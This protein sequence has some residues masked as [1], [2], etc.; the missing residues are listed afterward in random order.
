MFLQWS[1]SYMIITLIALLLMLLSGYRYMDVLRSNLEHT[2]GIQLDMTRV[3]LDQKLELLRNIT[4]KE[5]FS[6]AIS[7]MRKTT[8][9]DETPRYNYYQLT[10]EVTSDVLDYG[11]GNVYFLYF[12]AI[13]AMVSNAYYGQSQWFYDITLKPY[14]ISYD[15]W[16]EILGQE[17]GSTQVFVPDIQGEGDKRY[18]ILVRPISRSARADN[19]VNAVLMIDMDDLMQASDWLSQDT[20]CIV[21]RNMD[22]FISTQPVEEDVAQQIM[23]RLDS[24]VTQKITRAEH[25]VEDGLYISMI[26]S[27]Y[28]NWDIAV[29]I[30]EERF[31]SKIMDV[32]KLIACMILVYLVLIALVVA[33]SA[34]NH[35][36]RLKNIV[37]ALSG[38]DPDAD[39]SMQD[40]Y[41]YIDTSVQRLVRANVENSDVI[42]RQRNA[43][44]RELFLTLVAS[45]NTPVEI[46]EES[47]R[48]SGFPAGENEAYY[49]MGYRLEKDNPEEENDPNQISEMEWFILQNVTEES[50]QARGLMELCFRKGDTQVY[51]IWSQR[52]DPQTLEYIQEACRF[53]REFLAQHFDFRYTAAISGSHT[54]AAGMYRAWRELRRVY[55]YQR[56]RGDADVLLYDSLALAPEELVVQ[57]P[58]D[59]EN[60]LA[61]AVRSGDAEAACG[62]IREV[63]RQ[64]REHYLSPAAVQFLAGKIMAGI[65]REGEGMTGEPEIVEGQNRV[66]EACQHEDP[67]L[68]EQAL[69]TL[70]ET[71]CGR[72]LDRNRRVQADEKS[73]LYFEIRRYIDANYPDPGLNVNSVAEHFGRQASMISRYFKEMS[74]T[75]LTRY[76]HQVR[77]TYVKQ[78]LMQGEK[79]EDIATACG[80]GSQRSFLRIFKQY[81]GVTPSQYKELHSKEGTSNENL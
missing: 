59:A 58:A 6:S 67:A 57:Y 28:E 15:T 53:C 44:A 72:L 14:G 74:G 77:L 63:L 64:N 60:R 46:T 50:L 29:I 8:D 66:M 43:I 1:F 68:I 51:V 70:A 30:Q 73:Q 55:Q 54:G 41:A 78:K 76:I 2:N 56:S 61:L 31:A 23:N 19:T 27:G 40:A 49:L 37:D 9:Y 71:V 4:A 3:W 12:P 79:L 11:I 36:G 80:F 75:N 7:A 33:N 48:R 47:L 39:G 22:K 32:Q 10:K 21:D 18:L 38:S 26:S 20:L 5:S 69:C 16:M 81:E 45:S 52:Q 17:Y 35:Y 25:M 34:K 42:E 62:Q 65:L 13:D 24:G